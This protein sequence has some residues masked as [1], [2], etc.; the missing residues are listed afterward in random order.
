MKPRIPGKVVAGR[1]SL[2]ARLALARVRA[3]RLCWRRAMAAERRSHAVEVPLEA[4]GNGDG[5]DLDI[6]RVDRWAAV[7][8][9]GV[10]F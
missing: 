8:A 1:F 4:L 6:G 2:P 7:S 3:G 10:C 9:C 5:V